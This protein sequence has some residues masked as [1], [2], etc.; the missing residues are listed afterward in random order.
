MERVSNFTFQ[1]VKKTKAK[2]IYDAFS[3]VA[4]QMNIPFDI[5][6]KKINKSSDDVPW[7]HEQFSRFTK[8]IL[9]GSLSHEEKPQPHFART[10]IF[11][12]HVDFDVFTKNIK[13]I[14]EGLSRYIYNL[15]KPNISIFEEDLALSP[16]F[17]NSWIS[18]I[19]RYPRMMPYISQ[20]AKGKDVKESIL[21][22]GLERELSKHVADVS[23]KKTVILSKEDSDYVFFDKTMA[24]LSAYRV[25]PVS[26]DVFLSVCVAVYLLVLY[27]ILK[28]PRNTWL[29]ITQLF[30]SKKKRTK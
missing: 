10:N 21:I 9:G 5:V 4:A 24:T 12:N 26:F 22:T 7:Q 28:G 27:T 18:T 13:F 8:R 30:A 1:G 14:A 3:S 11:D 20:T 2:Q 29:Q 15:N 23:K 25:K 19:S 6:H 17:T 16:D